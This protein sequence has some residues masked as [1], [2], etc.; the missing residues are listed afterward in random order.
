MEE[1]MSD[2]ETIKRTQ[3]LRVPVLPDEKKLILQNAKNSGMKTAKFLR[4]IGQGYEVRGIVDYE[5]V[6]EMARIN[7]DL[8]RLGGLLKLWLTDDKKTA[9]FDANVIRAVLHKI[10]NNQAE[11]G[12]LMM[13]IVKP[14]SK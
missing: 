14:K 4:E 1:N 10:E 8:G 3:H 9:N 7:G 13:A 2:N 5:K 12:A 6:S 11:L